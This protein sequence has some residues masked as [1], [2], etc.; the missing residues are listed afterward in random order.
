M[1]TRRSGLRNLAIAAHGTGNG[2][3]SRAPEP[4]SVLMFSNTMAR[5]GAEEHML[6]LARYLDRKLFKIDFMCTPVVAASI[7]SDLPED[8]GVHVLTFASPMHL[9]AALA[10]RRFLK[11]RRIQILH[12]HMFQSSLCASPVGKLAGVPAVIETP[13]VR[14]K[15]RK[16]WKSSFLIDRMAAHAVDRFIAVSHANAR[17]LAEEKGLPT[18][19]ITVIQN[20][21]DISRID[22]S[23]FRNDLKRSLGFQDDDP[24]LLVAA[25]LE[26]Q[27]GHRV[28]IDAMATITHE[29]PNARLICLGE[30]VLRPTLEAQIRNRGVSKSVRMLGFQAN[31]QDWLGIC[32]I[33]VLPSFYEGLPLVAVEASACGKPV[34]ATDVD[35]TPEIVV[36]GR[37]GLLVPPGDS[38]KLAEAICSLLKNPDLRREFGAF[39]RSYVRETF[40]H[41]RQVRKTE[42]C[43]LET[44]TFGASIANRNQALPQQ[45]V[46]S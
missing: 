15:W 27:K 45:I 37:S 8:V 11:A 25:R 2:V 38:G 24:V 1:F 36:N 39:G 7:K 23:H 29:F 42:K 4:L 31:I 46:G 35:G 3:N 12:S 34:V 18:E 28:L 22:K 41:D 26:E 17:Y 44:W 5:G 6:L 10:L 32:D 43:Y 19:K 21:C 40:T 30:G 33:S 9:G 14:E 20:G 13:H 16:G